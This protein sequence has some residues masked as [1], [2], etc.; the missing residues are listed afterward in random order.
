M[1]EL[2]EML[3]LPMLEILELLVQLVEVVVVVVAPR[4]AAATA[5]TETPVRVAAVDAIRAASMAPTTGHLG[6]WQEMQLLAETAAAPGPRI[7][8]AVE[9]PAFTTRDAVGCNPKDTTGATRSA[10]P[11]AVLEVGEQLVVLVL[12]E[13]RALAIQEVLVVRE[14]LDLQQLQVH[15]PA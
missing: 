6:M 7:S 8:L 11:M 9:G 4:W 3:E 10:A 14:I 15:L 2:L 13:M 1:L 12:L 5:R